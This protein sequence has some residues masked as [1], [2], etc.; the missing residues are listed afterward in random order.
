MRSDKPVWV[1]VANGVIN[2]KRLDVL[3][4]GAIIRFGG[5]VTMTIH[6]DQIPAPAEDK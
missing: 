6:P 5:G 4:S 3:D 1:K 2:A